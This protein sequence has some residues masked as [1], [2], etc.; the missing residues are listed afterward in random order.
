MD[1]I[2][3]LGA[4]S[5]LGVF[6]IGLLANMII[7]VPEEV[8]LVTLGYLSATG[9][10]HVVLIIPLL[11]SGLLLS[12]LLMY[13]LSRKGSSITQKFYYRFFES[14]FSFLQNLDEKQLEK[15]IIFSRF[16][17]FF[18]FLAPFLGGMYALSLRRFIQLEIM[19]IT[20]YTTL[21]VGIGYYLRNQVEKIISGVNIVEHVIVAFVLLG[22]LSLL[23]V[24]L[25]NYFM[26][27]TKLF[28][29]TFKDKN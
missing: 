12:D 3:Q 1:F 8:T 2:H 23:F 21:Y 27:N 24:W 26:Q 15:I 14:Q 20:L 7:P 13:F 16:F 18:R 9:V 29:N 6:V 11:I 10:F 4:F 28:R 17:A 22:A 19:S 5:Y 25:R